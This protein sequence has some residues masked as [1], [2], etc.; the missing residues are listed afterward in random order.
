MVVIAQENEK[1][2]IV[3]VDRKGFVCLTCKYGKHE[4]KHIRFV[5]KTIDQ[6]VV[7]ESLADIV[8]QNEILQVAHRR[9]YA[10]KALS[11][12]RISIETQA[13]QKSVLEGS[14]LHAMVEDVVGSL[15]L[16]PV[17]ASKKCSGCGL[18][19]T[20][21]VDDLSWVEGVRLVAR[22]FIRMVRG[23]LI[24]KSFIFNAEKNYVAS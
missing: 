11:T 10:K 7:P 8:Q 9:V 14:Y 19:H 20:T 18:P 16:V 6:D 5:K 17:F 15:T 12:G 21:S 2:A 22:N 1:Q 3:G 4:C 23:K 13:S 24:Q